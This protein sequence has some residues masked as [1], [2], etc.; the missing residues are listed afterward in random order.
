MGIAITNPN[1]HVQ[2]GMIF[3]G[4]ELRGSIICGNGA[5]DTLI[6]DGRLATK[7][8]AGA[9]IDFGSTYDKGEAQ[10][11][12]YRVTNWGVLY[13]RNYLY[14]T[15]FIETSTTFNGL[16]VKIRTSLNSVLHS[17]QLR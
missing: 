4:P 16:A 13:L 10:E 7:S 8:V 1:G 15:P 17:I 2:S 11:L 6:L 9:F 14:F 12:R 3:S 5:A